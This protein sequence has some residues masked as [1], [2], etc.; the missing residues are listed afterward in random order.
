M[1]DKSVREV[2]AWAGVVDGRIDLIDIDDGWGGF[3][4]HKR[5]SPAIFARKVD[6]QRCYQKVC[7]VI[8]KP[9]SASQQQG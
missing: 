8:I 1:S 3:G 9:L 7:R 2:K 5:S 4:D 6:A